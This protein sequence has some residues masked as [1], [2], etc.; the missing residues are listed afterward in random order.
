MHE[1]PRQHAVT[2]L[3]LFCSLALVA[4][5]GFLGC[6]PG[7]NPA[8]QVPTLPPAIAT[9]DLAYP[10]GPHLEGSPRGLGI[11]R[12]HVVERLVSG[13]FTIEE[14]HNSLIGQPQVRGFASLGPPFE[15]IAIGTDNGIIAFT[16]FGHWSRDA[17]PPLALIL[18][19]VEMATPNWDGDEVKEW[20]EERAEALQGQD[21]ARDEVSYGNYVVRVYAYTMDLDSSKEK[22][23]G[24]QVSL[25]PRYASCE[26]ALAAKDWT[27]I[28]TVGRERG[29]PLWK[30]PT[31]P[32][33][34]GDGTVCERLPASD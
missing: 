34:D 8:L 1:A 12:S 26:D 24:I 9:P 21:G 6:E 22:Y 3:R 14:S 11:T 18:S 27:S 5:A 28:S 13:G 16:V 30:V 31:Q 15:V 4:V 25:D 20:V 29:Y 32:D 19:L 10:P 2:K 23:D 7:P 33:P 17:M